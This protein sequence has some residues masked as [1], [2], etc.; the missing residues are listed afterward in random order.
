MKR[1]ELNK[2]VTEELEHIPKDLKGSTQNE[3]RMLY[4]LIRRRE[5]GR[6]PA[7][8]AKDSLVK[9]IEAVKK[10]KPDFLAIYDREFF[11][12]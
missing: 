12:V 11:S 2:K 4:N 7:S 5:L 6:N 3:L 1:D 9:A 10:D 8:L